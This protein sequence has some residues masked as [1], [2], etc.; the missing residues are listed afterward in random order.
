MARA[1]PAAA[2]RALPSS[3]SHRAARPAKSTDDSRAMATRGQRKLLVM[4]RPSAGPIR[5]LFS[6]IKNRLSPDQ[7]VNFPR[8]D[9]LMK[10]IEDLKK[11]R[12]GVYNARRLKSA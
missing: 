12:Q 11:A 5:R 6:G 8:T 2:A 3:S 10:L 1:A 4:K 7:I 9:S